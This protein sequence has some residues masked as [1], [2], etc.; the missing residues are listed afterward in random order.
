ML[1]LYLVCLIIALIIDY[2]IAEKFSDIAEM[3]GHEGS[4]YFW[5]TFLF[6]LVGMLM[7]VAL[8][9]K[10]T[11]NNIFDFSKEDK[12]IFYTNTTQTEYEKSLIPPNG[13][14]ETRSKSDQ[15]I[16]KENNMITC[17][18]CNF[19]QPANRKVCWH[20]GTK[21]EE[22]NNTTRSHQWLCNGCKKMRTQSPCEHCGKE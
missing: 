15:S 18:L 13:Q 6:G 10:N 14:C 12:T 17:P 20:C 16:I 22:V 7:V 3:K 4:T 19:K 1:F 2:I 8:P 5:F 9:N 21:F 11:K